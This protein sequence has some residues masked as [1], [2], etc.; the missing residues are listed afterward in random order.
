[1]SNKRK[2]CRL[3]QNLYSTFLHIGKKRK[4]CRTKMKKLWFFKIFIRHFFLNNQKRKKCQTIRHF[5]IWHFFIDSDGRHICGFTIFMCLH[6]IT[7]IAAQCSAKVPPVA[8][9]HKT[10]SLPSSFYSFHRSKI[11]GSSPNISS[12]EGLDC[13]IYIAGAGRVA[14]W[15]V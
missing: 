3:L 4:K 5:C 11:T 10:K 7:G 15:W 2:K 6:E 8:L 9:H 14:K 1:M 12:I 13:F